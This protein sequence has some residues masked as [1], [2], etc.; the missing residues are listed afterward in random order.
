MKTICL[1]LESV[2]KPSTF[3]TDGNIT[4]VPLKKIPTGH[5]T[6]KQIEVQY[7]ETLF[8]YL[9]I[10]PIS[11]REDVAVFN[12]SSTSEFT[13]SDILS[14]KPTTDFDIW[15]FHRSQD[16]C[17]TPGIPRFS[18]G[19]IINKDF[20]PV[21][22]GENV[23]RDGKTLLLP[24]R[25]G[26]MKTYRKAV[27]S[28]SMVTKFTDMNLIAVEGVIKNN[29]CQEKTRENNSKSKIWVWALIIF[30]IIFSLII[31][32]IFFNWFRKRKIVVNNQG[33]V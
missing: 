29:I 3:I 23:M 26:Y 6:L 7:I 28:K 21:I 33:G 1:Y 5:P 13:L 32:Y 8:D 15:Y 27:E 17:E 10:T 14:K 16:R 18:G 4:L 2:H 9:S 19:Y 25:L 22:L 12:P 11:D 30:G 24:F 31:L 20:I